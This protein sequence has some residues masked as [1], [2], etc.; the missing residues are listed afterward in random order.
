MG[1]HPVC[2]HVHAQF[3]RVIRSKVAVFPFIG[4]HSIRLSTAVSD[5]VRYIPKKIKQFIELWVR[6]KGVALSCVVIKWFQKRLYM[7]MVGI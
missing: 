1:H 5:I 6:R 7:C 2:Y 4:I 3:K